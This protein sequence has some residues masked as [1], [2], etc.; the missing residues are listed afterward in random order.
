MEQSD[1]IAAAEGILT[2]RFG[3]AQELVDATRLP[4]SG[5]AGVYRAKVAT[6]PFLQHRSVVVKYSPLVG[7]PLEDAAYL[8]EVVAYQFTTS[9]S[10]EV[11]PG[12]V[13]LGYDVDK[14]IIIITDSGDGDTLD[15]LLAESTA[16]ERVN[17]LRS[18]GSALGRMHAGTADKEDAFNVLFSRLT[19]AHSGAEGVQNL[20]DR[21]LFH[22]IRLGLEMMEQAGIEVPDEVKTVAEHGSYRL[23]KG[24]NR[25]FTPFDLAPD[26]V[27]YAGTI[28]FLDYEWAGFR[29]VTFDLASVIAGFPNYI[30]TDP[31]TDEEA[32]VFTEAW[33]RE[34]SGLWPE[35]E[36]PETL[37]ARITAALIAWAL[38]S[39]SVL[40]VNAHSEVWEQDETITADFQA[41]G[42]DVGAGVHLEEFEVSGDLLRP[43]HQGPFTADE[44]LVRRDLYETFEALA[45]YSGAGDDPAYKEISEFAHAVAR[46]LS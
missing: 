7:D 38:S 2:R 46:R 11:R 36:R 16:E 41:A 33:V 21:L 28:Q 31:I 22:R 17:V 32:H 4:G 30:S 45:R 12:P 6:N 34:V 24:G 42:V 13:L 10:E 14:R 8:R 40:N 44:K 37:H 25:A 39:V 1:V 9:L 5:L 15:S 3:G 29:D 18:F 23:L 43:S 19:R 20:R 35:V 26:N 27:I